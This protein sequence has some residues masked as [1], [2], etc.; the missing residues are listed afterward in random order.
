MKPTDKQGNKLRLSR[1]CW[2]S[3]ILEVFK[4]DMC[5]PSRN[6]YFTHHNY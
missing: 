6:Q 5:H 4:M 1:M 2:N 3:K